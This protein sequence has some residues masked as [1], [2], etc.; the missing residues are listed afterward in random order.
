MQIGKGHN[1][2][3]LRRLWTQ[4]LTSILQRIIKIGLWFCFDH[5]RLLHVLPWQF[6]KTPSAICKPYS[7]FGREA[8]SASKSFSIRVCL[9]TCASKLGQRGR[10]RWLQSQGKQYLPIGEHISNL[11][12]CHRIAFA[13][14]TFID[15]IE[16]LIWIVYLNCVNGN[17]RCRNTAASPPP[18]MPS[19]SGNGSGTYSVA[20]GSHC[21]ISEIVKMPNNCNEEC[22]KW[23]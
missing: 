20:V 11:L 22:K 17:S 8:P 4:F 7:C 10:K 12:V 15:T 5:L 3:I 21:I 14:P 18:Q 19:L 6:V 9:V 13:S 2:G 1:A 23:A 16:L